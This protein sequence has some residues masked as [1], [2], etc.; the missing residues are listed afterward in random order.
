MLVKHSAAAIALHALVHIEV[1]H[2]DWREFMVL[3]WSVENVQLLA[4]N[5]QQ[6]NQSS[7]AAGMNKTRVNECEIFVCEIDNEI[8][9]SHKR[10]KNAF[11][12]WNLQ[13][14]IERRNSPL[15]LAQWTSGLDSRAVKR[16]ICYSA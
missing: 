5:L 12:R 8:L 3:A 10:N 2:A 16:L 11:G 6:P 14:V 9:S 13:S 4:A 1:Q 7:F 15:R